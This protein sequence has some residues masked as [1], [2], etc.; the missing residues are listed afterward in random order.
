[1][2]EHEVTPSSYGH[3]EMIEA[4][5]R[6]AESMALCAIRYTIGRRSYIVGDGQ[7]WAREWGARSAWVRDVIRRDLRE[8]AN[9]D[10]ALGDRHDERGWLAVLAD[11]DALAKEAGSHVD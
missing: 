11:L 7:R 3:S 4:D 2:S 5:P 8:A 10:G 1:M 6:D 9:R